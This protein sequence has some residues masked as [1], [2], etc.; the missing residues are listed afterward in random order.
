METLT[1]RS[2]NAVVVS[3]MLA[4]IEA[5]RGS[6]QRL[7]TDA[8]AQISALREI[9][10]VAHQAAEDLEGT[11]SIVSEAR[12]QAEGAE[13]ELSAA[14]SQIRLL[15]DTVVTL[16]ELTRENNDAISEL[17]A[18]TRR[19]DTIVNFVTDVS[20]QTNLLALNASIEAARAGDHGRGFAVVAR[21]VRKLAD[22]TRQATHEMNALLKEIGDRGRETQEIAQRADEAVKS[23]NDAS[24]SAGTALNSI[25]AAITHSVEAFRRVEGAIGSQASRSDEVGRSAEA[26]RTTARAH[27]GTAA[28][29]V[30][31]VN[32]LQFHTL[33]I[34]KQAVAHRSGHISIGS[35]NK[36]DSLPGRMLTEFARLIKVKTNGALAVTLHL[37]YKAT[38]DLQAM[39][40]VRNGELSVASIAGSIVGNVIPAANLTDLP[41]LFSSLQHSWTVYDSAHG[42]QLLSSLAP[43]GL[44]GIEFI[45]SGLRH[46][47]NAV[48]PV[49]QPTDLAYLRMR[50]AESPVYIYLFDA[51]GAI[52]IPIPL[53]S[54]KDA[55]KRGIVNAFEI[56]LVNLS[57][58]TLYNEAKYLTLSGH[59]HSCHWL[60]ANTQA[61]EALGENRA[62]VL[63]AAREAVQWQRQ[64][65]VRID[66]ELL[67]TMQGRIEVYR[68]T[69]AERE[70]F[71]A[72]SA[73]VY[74][75]MK[76]LVGAAAVDAIVSAARKGRSTALR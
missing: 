33:G 29:S 55:M 14:Q 30:V 57:A 59:M 71:V 52:P 6:A 2:E 50:V 21:E 66:E 51:L 72:A 9:V 41:F 39:S 3:Q 73:P 46:L 24:E 74:V 62:A 20:A 48:R 34:Q 49:H 10:D 47:S 7:A 31:S 70:A 32:A 35:T 4:A 8:Q 54:L 38:T 58:Y 37:P 25:D 1:S 53:P 36:P 5:L 17:L 43:F 40:D 61:L 45:E 63:E 75:R 15:V 16:A 22:S 27:Y 11:L 42:R 76:K 69:P 13:S 56:P 44:A 28:E 64:L 19:I 18:V 67:N 60:I 68:L 23:S 65:A 12:G 26:L